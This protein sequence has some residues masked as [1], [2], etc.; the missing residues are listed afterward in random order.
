MDNNKPGICLVGLGPH[1]KKIYY[2]YIEN[3]VMAGRLDFYLLVDLINKKDDIQFF[4]AQR[5][6]SPKNIFFSE[7]LDQ[8]APRRLDPKLQIILDKAIKEKKISHAIIST[9]PK[10]HRVY[11]EYFIKKGVPVLVDKPVTAPIG[12]NHD[13]GQAAAITRDTDYLADLSRKYNTAVYIQAQ[14]REHAAYKYIFAQAAEVIRSH[15]VPIT[16]FDMYHCDGQWSMPTEFASRE[17][18]PHKYGY[19]KLMHSGYHF[20]DL[21]AWIAEC[22]RLIIP[23]LHISN[24]TLLLLPGSHYQQIGGRHLYKSI[25]GE[26]TEP[27]IDKKM[28]E[29]DSYTKF[30]FRSSLSSGALDRMVTYGNVN[31]LQS[32]FSRRSW[33][34]LPVDTYKGNGRIRHEYFN[35]NIGPLF[36]IQFHSYQ[37]AEGN[38]GPKKGVGSRDHLTVNIFRNEKII[39]GKPLEI[40][41]FGKQ[42]QTKM[43]SHAPYLG[44]NEAAR[45]VV[46]EKMLAGM[47]SA[48]RIENQRLTSQIVSQMYHSAISGQPESFQVG[49]SADELSRQQSIKPRKYFVGAGA[50]RLS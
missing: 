50:D 3:D 36:N 1:A 21:V 42:V 46:Y 4:C 29:V 27:P 13:L 28:G 26:D 9:E 40:I 2:S 30:I 35:I 10:A 12:A 14:R 45:R 18:H 6:I 15:R 38:G 17:N 7:R 31:L 48:T 8:R 24:E 49:D 23:D 19:G 37:S 22:N 47:P 11:A 5:P 25:F 32:G 33:P 43:I 20:A 16:F 34:H 44:H 39:G 41:D